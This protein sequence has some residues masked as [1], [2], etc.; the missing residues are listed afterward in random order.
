M[1][2]IVFDNVSKRFILRHQ[3]ARSFQDLFVKQFKRLNGGS[4][5]AEE[6]WALRDVSFEISEGQMVGLIGQNGAGK[7]TALKLIA[8]I[9]EPTRGKVSVRGRLNAL[10]E[11]GAGFHEE[12]TGRE[13]I[14]L[15]G[16]L[17]GLSRS[18]IQKHFDEIVEFSEL[19]KFIDMQVKH[20]SSGMHVRLGFAIA[21]CIES[22]ILLIDEV[23]S[24]GDA[25]FQRKCLER[26]TEIREG[27]TT[28]FYVSHQ[29]SQIERYC[30]RALLIVNGK[31]VLDGPP[32]EVLDKYDVTRRQAQLEREQQLEAQ[33]QALAAQQSFYKA[34]YVACEVPPEMQ[35]GQVYH[36]TVT[37]RNQASQTWPRQESPGKGTTSV[38]YHWLDRWGVLYQLLNP[39]TPLPRDVAPG[40]TITV[41]SPVL[42][43]TEPGEYRLEIDMLAEGH[44][45]FSRHGCLGP[46]VRVNVLP[47]ARPIEEG[48]AHAMDRVSGNP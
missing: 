34:D 7:S 13:N 45:W 25:N 20:Y 41:Q 43:P 47:A 18:E 10:I 36:M 31:L 19:E 26:I 39:G 16:A 48:T 17:L 8:R 38:S 2:A 11:L 28:I 37:L 42:T 35:I 9:F 32:G 5:T 24:V 29:M 12:L 44:G 21:T 3:K 23:L 15:N 27:G 1:S 33:K 46:Q 6:F 22:E 30:D 40:E 4:S 14:Y